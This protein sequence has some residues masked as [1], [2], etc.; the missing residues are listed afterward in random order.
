M[1]T[2]ESIH[3]AVVALVASE[4]VQDVVTQLEREALRIEVGGAE[5][6]NAAPTAGVYVVTV[7]A[8]LGPLVGERVVAWA[9]RGELHP[10]VIGLVV[11]GG[12]RERES[13]LAAGF[14]DVVV[15]PLSVRELVARV[16]AVHRRVSWRGASH[17]RLRYGGY[18][19]DVHG[20]ALWA[21]GKVI[22]LTSLELAV[23]RELMKARGR[24]RSRV[25]L[26]AAAWGDGELD[27]SE[28]SVDNVILRL[29]RK[30]P[31]PE[32]IET[33]RSVGFRLAP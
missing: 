30:L 22:A 33:V 10:G 4:L 1:P 24:S 32:L 9:H 23:L 5:L 2:D 11:D 20:H 3:V 13:L 15:A 14:D 27:V 28:R 16:R 26:L 6:M 7:D 29:R 19:L 17:G 21:D 8:A 18:T 31:R 12:G 25:E